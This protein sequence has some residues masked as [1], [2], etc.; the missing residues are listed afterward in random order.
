MS[1]VKQCQLPKL[2]YKKVVTSVLQ[3][4]PLYL[5]CL[6]TLREVRSHV[7]SCLMGEAQEEAEVDIKDLSPL[8]NSL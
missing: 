3:A 1:E 8:S 2:G 4:C 7:V 5:S 6:I